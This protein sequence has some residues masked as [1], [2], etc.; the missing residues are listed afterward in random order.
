MLSVSFLLPKILE[1]CKKSS[2]FIHPSNELPIFT[3]DGTSIIYGA[4]SEVLITPIITKA[5]ESLSS[6]SPQE[7]QCL[8]EDEVQLEYFKLYS[9]RACE[10]ECLSKFAYSKCNCVPFNYAR[11]QSMNLC[12]TTN[13]PCALALEGIIHDGTCDCLPLCDSITYDFEVITNK[14]KP[15]YQAK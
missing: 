8:F 12:D 13:W 14:F 4:S 1:T 11:N 5:D 3:A 10:A 6:L 7:R 2:F 9:K 15:G